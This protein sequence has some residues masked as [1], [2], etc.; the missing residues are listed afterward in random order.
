M[1][2]LRTVLFLKI[3][4]MIGVECNILSSTNT[5]SMEMLHTMDHTCT[6]LILTCGLKWGM[7]TFHNPV[8][9]IPTFNS[10][11]T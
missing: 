3:Q 11:S 4:L 2:I 1:K 9:L 10:D 8:F 5:G 7:G 6:L